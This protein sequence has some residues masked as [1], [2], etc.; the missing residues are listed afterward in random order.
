MLSRMFKRFFFLGDFMGWW[1]IRWVSGR[2]SRVR[3]IFRSWVFFMYGCSFCRVLSCGRVFGG[4]VVGFVFL[5]RSFFNTF[6]VMV[7]EYLVRSFS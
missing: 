4:D 5:I 6:W 2:V 7:F 1:V 3:M